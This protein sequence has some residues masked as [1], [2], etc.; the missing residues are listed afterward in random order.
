MR[1]FRIGP[2]RGGATWALLLTLVFLAG[3]G[4]AGWGL[5]KK[6]RTAPP[7]RSERAPEVREEDHPPSYWVA[8]L[9]DAKAEQMLRAQ[10]ARAVPSLGKALR[11]DSPKARESATRLL[12]EYWVGQL[13]EPKAKKMLR[14]QGAR[15][16]P[17]LRK[18]LRGPNRQAR[19]SAALLLAEVGDDAEEIVPELLALLQD[20]TPA[21]RLAALDALGRIGKGRNRAD[22][23]G[24]LLPLVADEDER[25]R[26]AALSALDRLGPPT[27]KDRDLLHGLLGQP[28][29]AKC[30][31]L[32]GP[33]RVRLF[34]TLEE[35][36]LEQPA[37]VPLLVG[38]L[39][40]ADKAV[41]RRAVEG[42]GK[43]GPGARAQ[44]Y[45]G[46][47]GALK[48]KDEDV[49]RA[50]TRALPQ[51]GEPTDEDATALAGIVGDGTLS[52]TARAYAAIALR[53][54]GRDE[55]ERVFGPLMKALGSD[56]A[57]VRREAAK[58]LRDLGPPG[59]ANLPDLSR[60]LATR[61]S[62]A[63]LR[64]YAAWAVG[65]LGRD[66]VES[67]PALV[68]ALRDGGRDLRRAAVVALARVK[69]KN[70]ATAEALT[71]AL[72]DDDQDLRLLAVTALTQLHPYDAAF[73]GLL[74]A[75]Q[76]ED[77]EVVRTA[78][79]GLERVGTPPKESVS[80]LAAALKGPQLHVRVYAAHAL[81]KLGADGAEA[82]PALAEALEDK[83]PAVALR[84][85]AALK[86]LGPKAAGAA[87]ALVKAMGPKKPS[88]L[89]VEAAA[90][91]VA[92]NKEMEKAV[93]T[94]L[95]AFKNASDDFR[96]AAAAALGEI[97]PASS[98]DAAIPLSEALSDSDLSEG[99]A[100]A[101]VRMGKNA[102][103]RVEKLLKHKMPELRLR[104][105]V[106][107]G[108][109]GPPASTALPQLQLMA[110][111]ELPDVREAAKEARKRI[112]QKK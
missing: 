52:P 1:T 6:L 27:G 86:A 78:S 41:R 28:T 10:G 62:P 53:R 47:L 111:R 36:G 4:A 30:V 37:L 71:Q 17:F 83:H 89:R 60:A 58:T 8:R 81:A 16:V 79:T 99:A 84:C 73:D 50:A 110:A 65:E 67:G 93:T 51:V 12:N 82:V 87:P 24:A 94:L 5:V 29:P 97:G 23:L 109:I 22:Q 80:L 48:D 108:K 98:E 92:A 9:P 69:P 102:V 68:A 13:P 103:P 11:S 33:G 100:N 61:R 95:L 45:A 63:E 43:V 3:A 90:A 77:G 15:A 88:A 85:A 112:E 46:L 75:L 44:G 96:P 64:L 31:P 104:A 25:V 66:A 49:V 14:A 54:V 21:V 2:R 38:A 106:I 40:D 101:L 105:V 20:K 107:L 76:D 18:A 19:A 32:A 7:E 35:L 91:L 42:L 56:R 72:D 26:Q 70:R 74:K 39:K 34:A 57:G 55:K 59:V